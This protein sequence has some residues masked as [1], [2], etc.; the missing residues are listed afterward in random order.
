MN[1]AE[2]IRQLYDAN[3]DYRREFSCI[4]VPSFDE[5]IAD[6]AK[7]GIWSLRMH[8][9]DSIGDR[10]YHTQSSLERLLAAIPPEV[11]FKELGP[12]ALLWTAVNY[13][14][15]DDAH[16]RLRSGVKDLMQIDTV[17]L[18]RARLAA[19]RNLHET[20]GSQVKLMY[21][22]MDDIR[23][24]ALARLAPKV[25]NYPRDGAVISGARKKDY[26]LIPFETADREPEGWEKTWGPLFYPVQEGEPCCI[27]LD[28]PVAFGIGYKGIPNAVVSFL[29]E[30]GKFI[31][32][33]IQ[34]VQRHVI[35]NGKLV[36][37]KSSRGL[38]PLDWQRYLD[39]CV[40]DFSGAYGI[41]EAVW[42]G[43]A[44]NRWIE[45]LHGE[46]HM[47]LDEAVQKYDKVAERLGYTKRD[48][49]N[50]YKKV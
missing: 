43:G 44:N 17:K 18:E 21:T 48:D 45:P 49:N 19:W 11:I 33:Q 7:S 4:S 36:S 32:K 38:A 31:I 23:N 2:K 14:V 47:T 42:T 8:S 15:L 25:E 50:W 37:K 41:H 24:G 35:K 40:A 3:P 9:L 22:M 29:A 20:K 30:P 10:D 46:L 5:A 39:D 6:V 13:P 34:G 26:S 1:V 28:A 16:K 12:D 27:W